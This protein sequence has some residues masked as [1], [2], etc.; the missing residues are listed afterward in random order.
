MENKCLK[1]GNKIDTSSNYDCPKCGEKFWQSRE[2]F[3][4][5]QKHLDK[6][7][8]NDSPLQNLIISKTKTSK[9]AWYCLFLWLLSIV[10][11]VILIF[12]DTKF[13]YNHD[14]IGGIDFVLGIAFFIL[15]I[16]FFTLRPNSTTTISKMDTNYKLCNECFKCSKK[17]DD[18]AKYCIYCGEKLKV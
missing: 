4:I 10:L 8:L 18:D 7:S 6:N 16:V 13:N 9:L 15:M 12:I 11:F 5:Y 1:C 2:K 17:N 3:D 14:I